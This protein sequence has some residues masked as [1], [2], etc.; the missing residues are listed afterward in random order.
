[1]ADSE[2][3]LTAVGE[4]DMGGPFLLVA[5]SQLNNG[6]ILRLF[7]VPSKHRRREVFST[8]DLQTMPHRR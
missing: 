3:S 7:P 5:A 2:T 6:L 4:M 8:T 1:M